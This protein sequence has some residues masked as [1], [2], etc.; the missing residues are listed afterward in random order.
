MFSKYIIKTCLV[1]KGIGL[2]KSSKSRQ[3]LCSCDNHK[4]T[5]CYLCE[6]KNLS[7]YIECSNCL[8]I[9]EHWINRSTNKKELVWCCN[10]NAEEHRK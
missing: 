3:S 6:N 4:G 8:G 10:Q 7:E 5:R 1:C 2:I 9:G